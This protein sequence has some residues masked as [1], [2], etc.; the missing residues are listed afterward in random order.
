MTACYDAEQI[1]EYNEKQ[2]LH[3]VKAKFVIKSH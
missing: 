3:Q 1:P 2:A